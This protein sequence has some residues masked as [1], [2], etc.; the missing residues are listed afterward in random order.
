MEGESKQWECVKKKMWED[1]KRKEMSMNKVVWGGVKWEREELNVALNEKERKSYFI[2]WYFY[3]IYLFFF[4]E[5]KS[6][7]E[8]VREN[9]TGRKK[10]K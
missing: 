1:G 2:C 9:E 8:E 5:L 10:R 3:F 6:P 4:F 7:M